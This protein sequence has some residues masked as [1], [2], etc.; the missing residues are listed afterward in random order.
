RGGGA[1]ITYNWLISAQLANELRVNGARS[2][3]AGGPL[4]GNDLGPNPLNIKN[5]P[6]VRGNL[7]LGVQ[8]YSRGP[9]VS[10]FFYSSAGGYTNTSDNYGIADTATWI[11]S[12]HTFK[13]G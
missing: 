12:K 3:T 5:Y 1:T 7:V 2:Q 9:G 13:F 6:F 8:G 10:G 4:P 11:K